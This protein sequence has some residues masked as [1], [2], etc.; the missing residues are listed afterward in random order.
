MD[1]E[2]ELRLVKRKLQENHFNPEKCT[3]QDSCELDPPP[4]VSGRY[5]HLAGLSTDTF[6]Q[7]VVVSVTLRN[8]RVLY[9]FCKN[10]LTPAAL[11]TE[12]LNLVLQVN[13]RLQDAVLIYKPMKRQS[14]YL[15]QTV[16]LDARVSES[17]FAALLWKEM[18]NVTDTFERELEQLACYLARFEVPQVLYVK[19]GL[20]EIPLDQVRRLASKRALESKAGDELLPERLQDSVS[21]YS[22]VD[23]CSHLS[24]GAVQLSLSAFEMFSRLMK[25]G[26]EPRPADLSSFVV[27]AQLPKKMVAL[28]CNSY[29]QVQPRD[30][31]AE[32]LSTFLGIQGQTVSPQEAFQ[33]LSLCRMVFLR[34]LVVAPDFTCSS[35]SR[36]RAQYRL[37]PLF[38]ISCLKSITIDYYLCCKAYPRLESS[39]NLHDGLVLFPACASSDSWD[40]LGTERQQTLLA[41]AWQLQDL[42]YM[43]LSSLPDSTKRV[44]QAKLLLPKLVL[45][46]SRLHAA[47]G[48]HL[49]LTPRRVWVDPRTWEVQFT[50][51]CVLRERLDVERLPLEDVPFV[52]PELLAAEPTD[53]LCQADVYSLA[54]VMCDFLFP[55]EVLQCTSVADHL[56]KVRTELRRPYIPN[57]FEQ[58]YPEFTDVLRRSWEDNY[59]PDLLKFVW[60]SR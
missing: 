15:K 31:R 26:I 5:L 49:R 35:I 12:V 42:S 36:E 3:W 51:G 33:V 25:K 14:L 57:L 39:T 29:V 48:V 34:D 28:A 44:E 22:P 18:V 54:M 9:A 13:A 17:V 30:V 45:E 50:E 55:S 6:R 37:H 38:P 32:E 53:Q 10:F 23:Y 58:E 27:S 1:Q 8:T 11:R 16:F 52:A 7:K 56:T 46:L 21:V 24:M 41:Q 40:R 60:P 20:S 2:A 43:P 4:S 19:R 59:R 47:G